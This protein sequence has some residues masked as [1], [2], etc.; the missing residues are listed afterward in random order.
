[1]LIDVRHIQKRK[2]SWHYRRKVPASL[3]AAIGK[4]EI[5][6]R[7]AGS[8]AEA[9]RLYPSVHAE[10]E[11]QLAQAAKAT[12]TAVP[13][14]AQTA[15]EMSREAARRVA[16]LGLNPEWTPDDDDASEQ[17]GRDAIA[18]AV[19]RRH[20][21]DEYGDPIGLSQ[22]DEAFLS[23]LY[24]GAAAR[25]PDPTL[26]DAKRLYEK[27]RVR[28]SKKNK[29]ELERVFKLVAQAIPLTRTLSSLRRDDAKE[30]RS[31][32]LDGRRPSS[33]DRYLNTVRAVINHAIKEFDLGTL[34]N[35]FMG[36]EADL[37]ENAEPERKANRDFTQDEVEAVRRRILSMAK[38]DL[39]HIWIILENSGCRLSEVSGLRR[40]DVHLED[41]IP[42]FDVEWHDARRIKTKSSRRKVPLIGP[43]LQAMREA[44]EAHDGPFLFPDYC[45][46]GG[47]SAASAALSKHVRAVTT[48]RKV[49][50]HSLR[51]RMKDLLRLACV[52]DAVQDILLGHSSGKI[53]TNY[54]GERARLQVAERALRQALGYPPPERT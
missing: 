34:R 54:G 33:V 41:A 44:V 5:V 42:H 45:R 52:E 16:A 32:M 14:E 40:V 48:D 35:P 49:T 13:H 23:A 31:V 20:R 21:K 53:A 4:R 22:A 25:R 51:D 24:R 17:G 15:L 9:I 50:T 8:E 27:E 47:G 19:L 30:V 46:E 36:L 6:L 12:P 10:V 18:D 37:R 28:E 1:M 39:A 2:A 3:R 26:E 38:D 43:A 7:L 29:D 11:R